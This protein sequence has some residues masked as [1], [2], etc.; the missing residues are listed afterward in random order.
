MPKLALKKKFTQW[1]DFVNLEN[2]TVIKYRN[3]FLGF[4]ICL[5]GRN[6]LTAFLIRH[7]WTCLLRLNIYKTFK[8]FA[9]MIIHVLILSFDTRP[10]Y[11]IDWSHSGNYLKLNWIQSKNEIKVKTILTL[12]IGQIICSYIPRDLDM[13]ACF[14]GGFFVM[15]AVLLEKSPLKWDIYLN[16]EKMN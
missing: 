5:L 6:F 12:I 2:Q 10:P 3:N 1:S 15:P 11:N 4:S 13:S 9:F 14:F 7:W 8:N 16:N